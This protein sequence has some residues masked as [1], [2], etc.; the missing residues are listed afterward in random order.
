MTCGAI[1][2]GCHIATNLEPLFSWW[3]AVGAFIKEWWWVAFGA[4]CMALGAHM[5]PTKTY[6]IISAGFVSLAIR[7][8]PKAS[9][10]TNPELPAADQVPPRG[11]KT[12]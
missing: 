6:A 10:E 1:D 7:Y 2:I 8:W 12:R 11:K 5:G 9:P 3:G 4:A